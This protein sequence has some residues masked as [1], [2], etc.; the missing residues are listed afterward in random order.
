MH[1]LLIYVEY[2]ALLLWSTDREI[3]LTLI[4]LA[5]REKNN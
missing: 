3:V 4:K 5:Q 1:L 2:F